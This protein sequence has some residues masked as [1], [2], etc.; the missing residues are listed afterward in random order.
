MI[1]KTE[2]ASVSLI[3]VWI[4]VGFQKPREHRYDY[5]SIQVGFPKPRD[6]RYDYVSSQVGFQKP[7]EYRQHYVSIQGWFFH[8]VQQTGYPC[9]QMNNEV[10]YKLL[11]FLNSVERNANK[12]ILYTTV[13][14]CDNLF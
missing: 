7:R 10:S 14:E 6:D 2:R 13:H 9:R 11:R 1:S 5:V 4:Q 3:Y 12:Q 8:S